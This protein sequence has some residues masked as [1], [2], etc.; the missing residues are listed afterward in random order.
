METPSREGL[1]GDLW[2]S[3]VSQKRE[4]QKWEEQRGKQTKP[5]KCRAVL[6]SKTS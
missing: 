1:P 5:P 3:L 4:P 2:A 6:M